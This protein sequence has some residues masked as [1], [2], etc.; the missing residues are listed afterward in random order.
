MTALISRSSPR[1][2]AQTVWDSLFDVADVVSNTQD[3]MQYVILRSL[4]DQG[5]GGV[6]QNWFEI[7]DAGFVHRNF[8]IG[9]HGPIDGEGRAK[10]TPEDL[11][12]ATQV[13]VDHMKGHP[14]ARFISEARFEDYWNGFRDVRPFI[15]RLPQLREISYGECDGI[16]LC[17]VPDGRIAPPFTGGEWV[18]VPGFE[19]L[20]VQM[21][22][23]DDDSP[24]RLYRQIFLE[25]EI[26]WWNED[27][28][29]IG[30][31]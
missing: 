30:K 1:S 2:D 29:P 24:D 26:E 8:Q 23:E 28:E 25:R 11:F 15:E 20:L 21:K 4:S 3:A 7:D 18:R 22:D 5:T 13:S 14:D 17:W 19:R 12:H 27:G 16:M 6:V 10:F 9:V 31:S